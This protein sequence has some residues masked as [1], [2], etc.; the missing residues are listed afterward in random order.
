VIV[1][2]HQENNFSAISLEKKLLFEIT[3]MSVLY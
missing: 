1:V 3:M 2:E